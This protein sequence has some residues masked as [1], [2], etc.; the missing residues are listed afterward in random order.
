[1]SQGVQ[2][3]GAMLILLAYVLAHTGRWRPHAYPYL[4]ANLIGAG[5][6]TVSA[7]SERQ[8][9]FVLLEAVWTVAAAVG[10]VQRARARESASAG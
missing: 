6:L 4:W 10:I 9:G 2:I 1:V 5:V 7:F 8:W 3:V